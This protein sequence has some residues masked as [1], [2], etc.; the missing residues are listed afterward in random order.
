MYRVMISETEN[1]Q[2]AKNVQPGKPARHDKVD[3]GQYFTPSSHCW[4]SR[5]TAHI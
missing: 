3:L 5:G 4:F 1:P 2:E